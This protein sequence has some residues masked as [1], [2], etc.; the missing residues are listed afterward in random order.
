MSIL[1]PLKWLF[2]L[3]FPAILISCNSKPGQEVEIKAQPGAAVLSTEKLP[4]QKFVINPER[5]TII[6]GKSGTVLRIYKNTF[7][8][9]DGKPVTGNIEIEL[10]EAYTPADIVIAGLTT[11]SDGRLLETE[12]MIYVNAS[13]GGQ[14]LEIANDKFIGVIAPAG[15]V[16]KGMQI[17]EGQV[18]S[19]GINWKNPKPVLNDKLNVKSFATDTSAAPDSVQV[20]VS[21]QTR[22]GVDDI[23]AYLKSDSAG[24]E[25][26]SPKKRKNKI[27]QA[28]VKKQ[29]E[30]VFITEVRN[31]KG[32]NSF[33]E[34]SNTS[35]VF[36]L[37]NLGWANIDRLYEDPMTKPVELTTIIE[38]KKDFELVYITMV[39]PNKAMYL[40]G[41]PRADE[42]FGFSH[43]D[44]EPMQLPVGESAIILATAYKDDKPYYGIKEIKISEKQQVSFRLEETTAEKLKE[45]LTSSF[46][47][48]PE[49]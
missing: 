34:D 15:K 2:V 44:S 8:N 38:N 49:K 46:P 40:P 26:E 22:N 20:K 25:K 42:T 29:P 11:T 39:F 7:I 37:K 33:L 14:Q 17:F 24:A 35:Y 4:S 31:E 3:A 19:N 47:T 21:E 32:V 23:I 48:F 9:E 27:R 10:R 28:N 30:I 43:A 18:D 12:G 6:K 45:R 5:D 13:S 41:Y 36:S 16:K 1:I